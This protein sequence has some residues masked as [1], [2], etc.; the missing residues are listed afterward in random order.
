MA[1]KRGAEPATDHAV[2]ITKMV[3]PETLEALAQRCEAG[4][5]GREID[6]AVAVATNFATSPASYRDENDR[7][8]NGALV[9]RYT[10]SLDAVASL[11]EVMLPGWRVARICQHGDRW[12][13]TLHRNGDDFVQT[14][15][16]TLC[17]AWLAAALRALAAEI[18]GRS[19]G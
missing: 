10:T 3:A 19:D 7:I 12:D 5:R 16:L 2:D 4:E 1:E 8:V 9:P 11:T 17:L 18:R 15:A 13:V 6:L 14:D